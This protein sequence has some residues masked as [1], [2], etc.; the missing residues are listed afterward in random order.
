VVS[1]EALLSGDH[2]SSRVNT[3]LRS[4]QEVTEPEPE[5]VTSSSPFRGVEDGYIYKNDIDRLSEPVEYSPV[6]II[7]DQV[8][9]HPEAQEQEISDSISTS[10]CQDVDTGPEITNSAGESGVCLVKPLTLILLNF[11]GDISDHQ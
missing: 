10:C 6:V 7:K 8:W 2:H 5:Y 9:S 3:L 11:T 4:A 1:A